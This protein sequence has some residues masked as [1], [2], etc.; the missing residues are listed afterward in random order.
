MD[1]EVIDILTSEI[2]DY[3]KMDILVS[4]IKEKSNPLL[5]KQIFIDYFNRVPYIKGR[6][7]THII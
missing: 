3:D 1:A 5:T 4:F 2:I 6:V 7:L